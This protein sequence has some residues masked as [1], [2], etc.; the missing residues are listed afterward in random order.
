MGMMPIVARHSSHVGPLTM[1]N[2]HCD[3]TSFLSPCTSYMYI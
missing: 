2:A 1:C 3:P